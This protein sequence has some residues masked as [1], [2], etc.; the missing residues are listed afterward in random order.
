MI[1]LHVAAIL[2]ILC[3]GCEDAA[4]PPPASFKPAVTPQESS[5]WFEDIAEASN[6]DFKWISGDDGQFLM[7]EIV[8]GGVA[9]LDFDGDGDLD[10]Y[11]VQGGSVTDA[12]RN[13]ESNTAANRLFRNDGLMQFTDV[14][15]ATGA[16]DG[17]FGMGVA[18][19]DIDGDG[20]PDLYVT[21]VGR[22]TMLRNDDGVFVDITES[23]GTG[24]QGWGASAAF[25]DAD[26][27]G[28]LD[29][30]ATNYLDWNPDT[31]ITCFSPLGGEDYCSP[32]NYLSPALDVFYR[33]LGDGRFADATVE[34]GFDAQSGT[35]L[36]IVHAD[37]NG[38][39]RPDIFIANDGM[40]DLLWMSRP[41]GTW[42]EEGMTRGCSLDDEGVAKAGM[43]VDT[44]D[45][46]DDGDFD[47]IVC[48]LTGE[49]DSIFRNDG[50]YFVDI[51]GRTGVRASTK[52]A[53][54][55]GLGW[56]DFDNDGWLDLYEAN[57]AVTRISVP[58]TDDPYAQADAVLKGRSGPKFTPVS[59][60][61]GTAD[62]IILT[63]RAAAFGDLDQDGGVDIVVV[64]KDASA[65]LYRNINSARGNWLALDIRDASG[66]PAIG[67]IVSAQLGER[68]LTRPVRRAS[69]YMASN[70]P[71]V[72]FGLGS[73]TALKNV[74]IQWPDGTVQQVGQL[75][76]GQTHRLQR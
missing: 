64:N 20:D 2:P 1:R 43:G 18:V 22:N 55:F 54:R 19:G 49:S 59:P 13:P 10:V 15:D 50:D 63:S 60:A 65:N 29:L 32:R 38:D 34:A 3:V 33:N 68:V 74:T 52:H 41:D 66:R 42:S 47:I 6:L 76:A 36:G 40:R 25:F 44:T 69:S 5:P 61:G 70:D 8:G 28:D 75:K 39:H 56:I 62:S 21:N 58:Q 26:L 31:E 24:D 48:N 35:G 14:S 72:H 37:W 45:L 7:P 57:G 4:P 17:G 73:A 53:T 67:A 12:W 30:F 23:S 9:L 46:D 11:F 51:T 27:D 16:A 71:R